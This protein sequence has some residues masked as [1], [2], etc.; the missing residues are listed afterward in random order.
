M[1]VQDGKFLDLQ[2]TLFL[3]NPKMVTSPIS[4]KPISFESSNRLPPAH[5]KFNPLT[6]CLGTENSKISSKNQ[7]FS[8]YFE[9]TDFFQKKSS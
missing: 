8:I 7:F 4:T 9:E 5:T 1:R 2:G 3:G 6:H